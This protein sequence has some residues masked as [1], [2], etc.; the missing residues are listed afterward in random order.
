MLGMI[1]PLPAD[2]LEI[3]AGLLQC[4]PDIQETAPAVQE[5]SK[6]CTV[7]CSINLHRL[8]PVDISKWRMKKASQ[9]LPDKTSGVSKPNVDKK[10]KNASSDNGYYL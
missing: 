9:E 2:D 5:Q 4:D 1:I 7:P 3:V 10:H 6:V 8:D